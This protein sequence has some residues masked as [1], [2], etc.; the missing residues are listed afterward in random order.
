MSTLLEALILLVF[1]SLFITWAGGG[2]TCGITI[3]TSSTSYIDSDWFGALA[4]SRVCNFLLSRALN[5]SPKNFMEWVALSVTRTS[6]AW[7]L[8]LTVLSSVN[9]TILSI[10]AL[11][12]EIVLESFFVAKWLINFSTYSFMTGDL[13]FRPSLIYSMKSSKLREYNKLLIL[14]WAKSTVIA[15]SS[16]N[17]PKR[18]PSMFL[19]MWAK[20][21]LRP[22][23][24]CWIMWNPQ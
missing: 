19:A 4:S 22:F 13:S 17:L 16:F 8:T 23:A 7:F 11:S 2:R 18:S 20:S 24:M 6:K 1:A 15:L 10:S 5:L 9:A 12:S 3:V 21:F 14:F